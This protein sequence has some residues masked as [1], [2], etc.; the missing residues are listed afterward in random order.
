MLHFTFSY[1]FL[2]VFC[3]NLMFAFQVSATELSGCHSKQRLFSFL[4]NVILACFDEV[5]KCMDGKIILKG[6][7]LHHAN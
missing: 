2:I 7:F 4:K 5:D 1:R 6:K 3:F